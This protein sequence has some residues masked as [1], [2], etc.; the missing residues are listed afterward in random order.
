[1]CSSHGLRYF[2]SCLCARGSM[3]VPVFRNVHFVCAQ[4]RFIMKTFQ[5]STT[6]L[7]ASGKL[8]LAT[9]PVSDGAL[10][11][12]KPQISCSKLNQI[13]VIQTKVLTE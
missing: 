4:R 5:G 7:I 2:S 3:E 1:M 9:V 8:L 13:I 11:A 6:Y 10:A 12:G